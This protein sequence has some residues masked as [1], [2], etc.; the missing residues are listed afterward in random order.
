MHCHCR[1]LQLALSKAHRPEQKSDTYDALELCEGLRGF[2]RSMVHVPS[3]AIGDL[4]TTL[5]R[6]RHFIR[7][8]TAEVNAV[9]RLLRGVARNSGRRGSLHTA[10]HCQRLLAG[11]AVPSELKECSVAPGRGAGPRAR[12][13]S[14]RARAN[15]VM[16]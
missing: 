1:A 16:L 4:R 8:Q 15:S 11:E 9:K 10:A 6:R 7:I 3:P 12:S 2:Y 13:K 5:S 14:R